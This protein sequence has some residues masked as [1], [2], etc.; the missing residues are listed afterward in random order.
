MLQLT[1]RSAP[2]MRVVAAIVV[3]LTLAL[4]LPLLAFANVTLTQISVDPFT[5]TTSQHKT[6]V[7][8]DSYSFGSTIVAVTQVGRF[9]NGGSS[10]IGWG[11]STDGGNTWTNGFLPGLTVFSTPAGPYDRVSDP[12]VAF[13]ASHNVWLINSLGLTGSS[14][15]VGAAA[16]VNRSTDGGQTWGNAI[17]VR[18][19]SG[20]Q[21]FDKNWITCDNTST[22]PFYGRCYIEYDDNG[23]GNILHMEYSTDGGLTW[24][25]SS[26]P[27]AFVI[28][29]QPV[30]QPNGTVVVPIDN[31]NETS[32]QSTLSTDGG[33]SY[34]A[35]TTITTI[36]KHT[37]AGSLRS[38]PLPSAEVD[39]AGTVYVVWQDCRFRTR[40][41]EN[42]IVM[43]T[44][45]NGTTWTPVVRVPI[46]TTSDTQDHFIPGIAVDRNTSGGSAHIAITYYYYPATR[47]SSTTCQLDVGFISSSTGGASWGAFTQLAGPM[48]LKWLPNTTLGRMVGDYISTSFS[49]GLAH[50]LFAEANVPT[51]GGTDCASA[52]PNCDESLNTNA[53]GM[54]RSGA[55]VFTS[56][57]DQPVASAASDQPASTTPLT[58]R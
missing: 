33:V 27:S 8:P 5:N 10:D 50:G 57:G 24:N 4:A 21:N 28:G 37:V 2:R 22:S 43:T 12:A 47:C 44:S 48:T 23:G 20:S 18:A 35:L 9:N 55:A 51:A 29:G 34:A 16:V 13:D 38:G 30:V 6:E 36:S 40:C 32:L 52:T 25:A 11:T 14:T 15:V 26:V 3:S 7:E 58:A 41:R 42:D 19:I 54:A 39:G 45:T 53:A 46:G 31:S 17:V 1:A 56:A 49:N